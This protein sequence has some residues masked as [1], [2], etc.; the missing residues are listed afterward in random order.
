MSRL[1]LG[2]SRMT[3]QEFSAKWAN[4]QLKERAGSQEADNRNRSGTPQSEQRPVICIQWS[5]VV[6]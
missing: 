6:G 5:E 4:A 2:R 3:P 1:S